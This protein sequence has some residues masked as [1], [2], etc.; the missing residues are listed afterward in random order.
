MKRLTWTELKLFRQT[1]G[2][3]R[4][5]TLKMEAKPRSLGSGSQPFVTVTRRHFQQ[6]NRETES[7]PDLQNHAK[8]NKA[9]PP[10]TAPTCSRFNRTSGTDAVSFLHF[11][12]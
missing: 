7:P 4:Q 8:K 6:I 11:I 2:N 10:P 3:P 9:S 12:V 5:P 1:K